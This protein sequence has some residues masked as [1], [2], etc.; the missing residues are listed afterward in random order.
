MEGKGRGEKEREWKEGKGRKGW[1]VKGR[2]RKGREGKGETRDYPAH[3]SPLPS[4]DGPQIYDV[5]L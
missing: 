1:K 4:E 3:Y 5:N 2:E